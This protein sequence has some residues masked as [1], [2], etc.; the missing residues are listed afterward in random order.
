MKKVKREA[1]AQRRPAQSERK[2]RVFFPRNDRPYGLKCEAFQTENA[3]FVDCLGGRETPL[4][5]REVLP[6]PPSPPSL[7]QRAFLEGAEAFHILYLFEIKC[8]FLLIR[9]G[10]CQ[11]DCPIRLRESEGGRR[12]CP[13][14]QRKKTLLFHLERFNFE[15]DETRR[16]QHSAAR[17]KVSGKTALFPRNML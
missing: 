10:V 15:K 5:A 6:F 17:P 4:L 14:R 2:N 11:H 1:A 7:P 9:F 8:K 16:R 3:L 13:L 12:P